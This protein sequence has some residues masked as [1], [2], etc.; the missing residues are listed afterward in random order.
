MCGCAALPGPVLLLQ[1]VRSL[2][3]SVD[4]SRLSRIALSNLEKDDG[5]TDY[6]AAQPATAGGDITIDSA[7]AELDFEEIQ[8]QGEHNQQAGI[9]CVRWQTCQ[10]PSNLPGARSKASVKQ[11]ST[12]SG[13]PSAAIPG[14]S[15][16]AASCTG[17]HDPV[18]WL[19]CFCSLLPFRGHR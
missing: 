18:L 1:A 5:V 3:E 11:C 13:Q 16:T 17:S 19:R 9:L 10:V 6:T 7:D 4:L 12:A 8:E 14:V 2:R 15:T